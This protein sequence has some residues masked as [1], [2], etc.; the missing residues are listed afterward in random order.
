M[1][2]KPSVLLEG[3]SLPA[4]EEALRRL[5]ASHELELSE[6]QTKHEE[7]LRKLEMIYESKSA[8]N[9]HRG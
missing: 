9:R 2:R 3:R 8:D 6:L 4:Y 5:R 1:P 7:E